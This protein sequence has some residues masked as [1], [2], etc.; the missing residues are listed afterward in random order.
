MKKIL[1]VILGVMGA[2]GL[3]RVQAQILNVNFIDDSINVD[4]GGG[5]VPPP[6]AMSG[7]AVIGSAGD[8][9]NGL[10]GFAYSAYPDGATFTSGSL[11]YA[12][13]S[14]SAITL[15]LSAPSGTYDANSTGFN[16]HSPFSWSSLANENADIGYPNTPYAVLMASCI[17][18]NSTAANGFVTLSNLTPNG[19]Y[20]LYTYN[21]SDQNE[22]GG[23]TST[24]AVNGITQTSTYDGVTTTLSN[25]VD[26]LEFV[27]VAA[28]ATGTLT[29]NFGNLGVSESDF[30]GFQLE[31]TNATGPPP[32]V[33][34]I[35]SA[36]SP[37]KIIF[38]TN[39]T[40]TCTAT[41]SD[42]TI[43]NVQIITQTSTLGG[44]GSTTVTNILSSPVVT[45]LGTVTASV[46]YSLSTNLIYNVTVVATDSN[47]LSASATASFDT[48]TPAVVIE[49]EDFN[50]SGGQFTNTPPDGG[51]ALYANAPLGVSEIDYQK[52]LANG[53]QA[54]DGSYYRSNDV[55]ICGSAAPVNGTEQK[56][57][58]AAAN[59]DSKDVPIEVGYNGVGDW[60]DYTRTFG[61]ADTNSAPDGT[62][63]VWARLATSGSGTQLN[64]YEVT[65][66]E[67]TSSQ[68]TSQL[69]SFSFTD[70]NWNA[71][72]YVPLLDQFGNSVSVTLGG[73][74]TLRSTVVGNPN[75]DFY[76]LIPAVPKLTP[77]LQSAYP[78][79]LHPFE[80]A[81]NFTFTV[82]PANGSN[83]TFATGARCGS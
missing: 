50:Y 45:G 25:G 55:I 31:S 11:L 33:P 65:G 30:N 19:V 22:V 54:A 16:N 14:A 81:T 29:I 44:T 67:G 41:S 36:I 72:D 32:P 75:I 26:Y 20:N 17:V 3:A 78:D 76:M 13:G 63:S 37:N 27:Q 58:T 24:F 79:G 2:T 4:Y 7:A 48:L 51:L 6:S 66:G 83:P 40:L 60:L 34:P 5:N 59:S 23:R 68:T 38:C 71:F 39:E 15:S 46:S 10:G 77:S 18:A 35:V 64:F 56:Y 43:T 49:A 47:A 28:S 69:G 61:S 9:W 8:T 70:N 62:Y 80:F 1:L 42:A 53:S 57:V 52:N 82:G 73:S 74:E 21:A 12:N